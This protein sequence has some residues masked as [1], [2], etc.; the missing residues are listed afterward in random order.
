MHPISRGRAGQTIWRRLKL[1]ESPEI[2]LKALMVNSIAI[3]NEGGLDT[4]IAE[5]SENDVITMH[6]NRL[7]NIRRNFNAHEN[8]PH[9]S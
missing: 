4:V 6:C 9:H 7:E 8:I 3:E 1:P 5:V 2:P